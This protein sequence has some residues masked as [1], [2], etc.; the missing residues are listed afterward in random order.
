LTYTKPLVL[1]GLGTKINQVLFEHVR[2]RGFQHVIVDA[3]GPAIYHI[4]AKKLNGKVFS[5]IDT[6]TWISKNEN[7]DDYRP[8]EN[9]NGAITLIEFDL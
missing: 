1:I 8:L 5:S 4:Y 2:R 9:L 6:S 3:S 7:G